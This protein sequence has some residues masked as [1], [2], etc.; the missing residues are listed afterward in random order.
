MF[1]DKVMADAIDRLK[2]QSKNDTARFVMIAEDGRMVNGG[3][4]CHGRLSN[5]DSLLTK[6]AGVVTCTQQTPQSGCLIFK[7][8]KY[9]RAYLDY[10]MNRSPYQNAYL[11]KDADLCI[12]QDA[13]AITGHV[14][15]NLMAGACVATRSI[16]ERGGGLAYIFCELSERGVP[17]DVAF[18]LANTATISS[19]DEGR[20]IRWNRPEEDHHPFSPLPFTWDCLKN[21]L[22]HTPAQPNSTWVESSNYR[23][24][25]KLFLS[26]PEGQTNKKAGEVM[27]F[28]L[29]GYAGKTD[30]ATKNNNPFPRPAPPTPTTSGI[31][32]KADVSIENMAKF[33]IE[34]LLPKI[35]Q[36][37][38]V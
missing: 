19:S 17:E 28:I 26:Y 2:G 14:P 35:K 29:D 30:S 38:G 18:M 6:R 32:E 7:K 31:F 4:A 36:E 15:S 5:D 3:T 1:S 23:G 27:R 25:N 8:P 22:T 10:L 9:K 16:W 12:Q 24:L 34:K 20:T 37:T 21:F 13:I 11:S 33:A